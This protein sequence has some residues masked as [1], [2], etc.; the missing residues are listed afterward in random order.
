MMNSSDKGKILKFNLNV[1]PYIKKI[2][3]KFIN[4]EGAL[5]HT[6][7]RHRLVNK[8]K[9]NLTNSLALH[10]LISFLSR[11]RL[12]LQE[13]VLERVPKKLPSANQPI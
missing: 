8:H 2:L 5:E 1:S 13:K 6:Q 11:K 10:R 12:V 7:V 4:E 9:S 3:A